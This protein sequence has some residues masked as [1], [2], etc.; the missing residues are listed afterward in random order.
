MRTNKMM[1][2]LTLHTNTKRLI[3][4]LGI[5]DIQIPLYKRLVNLKEKYL[6]TL[7]EEQWKDLKIEY[8]RKCYLTKIRNCKE[9][10]TGKITFENFS[11]QKVISVNDIKEQIFIIN[12]NEKE[13]KGFIKEY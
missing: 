12:K 4:S 5:P 7:R 13:I 2:K 1:L 8:L 10:L 3:L 9:K 6:N 11:S